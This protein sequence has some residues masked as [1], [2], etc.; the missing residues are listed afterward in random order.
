MHRRPLSGRFITSWRLSATGGTLSTSGLTATSA[1]CMCRRWRKCLPMAADGLRL[2]VGHDW[3]IVYGNAVPNSE[4]HWLNS[5]CSSNKSNKHLIPNYLY[6]PRPLRVEKTRQTINFFPPSGHFPSTPHMGKSTKVEDIVA[7]E[8][9]ARS[10][11]RP[12]VFSSRWPMYAINHWIFEDQKVLDKRERRLVTTVDNS[13]IY[14]RFRR[15]RRR[16]PRN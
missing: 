13:Y 1:F 3:I 8:V 7:P 2:I 6:V 9:M 12:F 14:R 4:T 15:R 11:L 5:I 16:G 10:E